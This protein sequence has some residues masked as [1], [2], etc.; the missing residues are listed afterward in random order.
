MTLHQLLARLRSLGVHLRVERDRLRFNAPKGAMTPDLRA[1]L[2]EHKEALLAFLRDVDAHVEAPRM[3]IM[4]GPRGD[5]I[6]LSFAQ[7]RLW[8]LAQLEP[9][10]AAYNVPLA[11]CLKGMLDRQALAAGL[12][13]V[14]ARHEVLRTTFPT[15]AG[16]PIQV[17]HP[18][19]AVPLPLIDLSELPAA[20]RA[21]AALHLARAVAEQPFDLARGPLLYARLLRLA[22][23][24]HWLLL[25]MHHIVSDGWSMNVLVHE[26]TVLY[27]ARTRRQPVALPPLPVQYADY[28]HWQRGWLQGAVLERRLAYWREHLHGTATLNLPTDRPR[29]P[30][31]RFDGATLVFQIPAALTASLG[32][33]PREGVTLFMTLLAAFQTLLYRY[34]GQADIV[35]GSPIAGRTQV[36]TEGLIG[37]F[38][39]T[40]VLRSDLSGNPRFRDLLGR[41]RAVC[42]GAYAHQEVPFER[43]V[44]ELQPV[45][46]LSRTPLFQVLFVLQNAPFEP[47]AVPRLRLEPVA[48]EQTTA[49]FDLTLSLTETPEGLLGSLEYGTALFQAESIARLERHLETLLEGIVAD[50]DRRL[51]ALPLLPEPER[52]RLLVAWNATET[53]YPDT[54]CLQQLF[55]AQVARTPDAVAVVYEEAHLSYAALDERATRLAPLPLLAGGRTRGT[56]GALYRAKPGDAGGGARHPQGGRR[57]C[58]A[59]SHA[60]RPDV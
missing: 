52:R 24:E 5:A 50:P 21:T 22:H 46:D 45:R 56:G 29:P 49:K 9:H 23:E 53:P 36:E 10:S 19:H 26:L 39:N 25:S 41:V 6:P 38:V 7:Q 33:E 13:A 42:L 32:A 2:A 30:V 37:L 60:T 28:A 12:E 17:I 8:F 43:L 15:V 31:Q 57:L 58:A 4:P 51:A 34:S 35:V 18:A 3:A 40:L 1:E 20:A 48:F 54:N 16:K 11:V 59:G 47:I 55:E 44:E 14:V 27:D